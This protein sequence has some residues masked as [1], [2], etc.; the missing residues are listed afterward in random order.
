MSLFF[1]NERRIPR[2]DPGDPTVEDVESAVVAVSERKPLLLIAS[3]LK[4]ER[5]RAPQIINICRSV[6][7]ELLIAVATEQVTTKAQAV[8]FVENATPD[9]FPATVYV[10]IMIENAGGTAAA[11]L[12]AAIEEAQAAG[13]EIE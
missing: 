11:F 2:G 10:D 12:A 8:S 3:Y 9:W 7:H 1:K 4:N 13:V 5:D 6:E